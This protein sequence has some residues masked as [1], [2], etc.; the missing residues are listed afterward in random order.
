MAWRAS[1]VSYDDVARLHDRL[2]GSEA[3]AWTLVRRGLADPEAAEE[4]LRAD[5]P[6][7]SP[8][9]TAGAIEAA[10]R[11][12]KAIERGERIVVHGDY[13]CDGVCSAAIMLI[14][15]RSR[16]ASATAFLP[17]RFRDGYG[18]SVA[19]V[20]RIAE[21]GA[22]LLVTVDCGTTAVE[23]LT[24]AVD[25]G[26]DVVVI[27]HHLAAG[28]R[29]PGILVN[30]A[31]GRSRDDLPAAA[32]VAL[33]VVR[34]L[35]SLE[36]DDQL[37]A[38]SEALV[39][40]AALA[41]V[42]DQVPLL[43]DNRRLVARGLEQMRTTP[44]PGIAALCAAAGQDVRGVSTRTLGFTLGPSINAAGRLAEAER[45]LDL[46]LAP[47]IEA[48]TPIA[49]ELWKMNLERRELEQAITDEAVAQIAAWPEADR[50]VDAYVVSGDGWHEGV[51]GIV[52]SRLVERHRRPVIV[53]TRDGE[54]A[55]GS[56]R[57][58]PGVDLHA[59][60]SG[61]DGVLS[62]WGG[63]EGAVGVQLA[64]ADIA[65]FREEFSASAVGA[66]SAIA[67]AQVRQVDAVVSPTELTLSDAESLLQLEP[68]GRGNPAVRLALPGCEVSGPCT[69]GDGRHLRARL[70]AGNAHVP[71]IGFRMGEQAAALDEEGR[72]DAV[73]GLEIERY[74]GLVGPKVILQAIEPFE[75]AGLEASRQDARASADR[76]RSLL[77]AGSDI[78]AGA[79][80]SPR[81]IRD[82]RG[83]GGVLARLAAL[84]GADRGVVAVVSDAARRIEL[85]HTALAPGRLGAESTLVLGERYVEGA[86]IEGLGAG[87]APLFVMVDHSRIAELTLPPDVHVVAIDP[88]RDA[89]QARALVAAASDKWLHLLWGPPEIDFARASAVAQLEIRPVA[90]S[91]WRLLRDR[92]RLD[93]DGTDALELVTAGG[94]AL[95]PSTVALALRA[96]EEL[97]LI[98]ILPDSVVVGA[99]PPGGRLEDTFPAKQAEQRREAALR[100]LAN[101]LTVDIL[102]GHAAA[103]A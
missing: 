19:N 88:P 28:Q 98:R 66:R 72:Y 81:A 55:K 90:S 69:V 79:P 14:A 39:D 24:R 11:L 26:L 60:V 23:A 32:G 34:A 71:A 68:F 75:P 101:A 78:V 37:G 9:E 15:L 35:E 103:A 41:T 65:N 76:M 33:R 74:Q 20:E 77:E 38:A 10:T 54:R 70:R 63:H 93:L 44:R 3:L 89:E 5:G 51:V 86:P 8:Q 64:S 95:F 99:E 92:D 58:L 47:D 87:V 25:L 62:S 96:L 57:S 2:G 46:V 21:E 42:A 83:E 27:D 61:A 56:G 67:R 48:A 36:P 94:V 82:R 7:E 73:V 97:G 13:D 80:P 52:A 100:Y 16:G 30:P 6:L 91:L 31:L 29:P 49:R 12:A 40:L 43:G 22:R 17:S 85:L 18:V 102:D 4:F 59:I 50:A 1:R 53:L 45:G 84:T